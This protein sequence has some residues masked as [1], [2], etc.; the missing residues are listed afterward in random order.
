MKK[1]QAY[2]ITATLLVVT[3]GCFTTVGTTGLKPS[4]GSLI[5]LDHSTKT[6]LTPPVGS[7]T[8]AQVG[9]VIFTYM[10]GTLVPR[11]LLNRPGVTT[12][13][14]K[15]LSDNPA[16]RKNLFKTILREGEYFEVYQDE[17]SNKYYGSVAD[18]LLLKR[19]GQPLSKYLLTNRDGYGYG[20]RLRKHHNG[21][22]VRVSSLELLQPGTMDTE[23]AASPY[24][25]IEPE[26]VP[27][28]SY[29]RWELVFTGFSGDDLRLE[30]REFAVEPTSQ[31]IR[32]GFSLSLSYNIADLPTTI[33]YRDTQ[34][35][36][37]KRES[38]VIEYVVL[39]D[40]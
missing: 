19:G 22:T 32:P 15:N 34:I 9:D 36:I 40:N 17:M 5:Q 1:Y 27:D 13:P 24:R 35:Q 20:A 21:R 38:N 16:D 14:D 10:S 12:I 3:G 11:V 7:Q 18:V 26:F 33:N 29:V 4:K 23:S 39:T 8:S 2:L 31:I 37:L 30:Y 6:I 25:E 28:L